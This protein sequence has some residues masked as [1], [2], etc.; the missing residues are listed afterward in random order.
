MSLDTILKGVVRSRLARFGLGIATFLTSV[1]QTRADIPIEE[2]LDAFLGNKPAIVEVYDPSVAGYPT[3]IPSPEV[4]EI[5]RNDYIALGVNPHPDEYWTMPKISYGIPQT[6]ADYFGTV[7]DIGNFFGEIAIENISVEGRIGG[8]NYA[9]PSSLIQYE[10]D[11]WYHLIVRAD[12]P[13]TTDIIEGGIPGQS[14]QIYFVND[15]TSSLVGVGEWQFGSQRYNILVDSDQDGLTNKEETDIHFTD[16][17]NPDTD[18]DNRRDS[19][20]IAQGTDPLVCD[21]PVVPANVVATD[22]LADIIQVTWASS[23]GATDYR[24][25]RGLTDNSAQASVISDWIA[26]T[27]VT[28]TTASQNPANTYYYFVVARND[29]V[30]GDFS[31]SDQGSVLCQI[32]AAPANVD[33]TDDLA[34]R[35]E[36]TW[37]ASPEVEGA[38]NYQVYRG[39]SINP[40][41]AIAISGSLASGITSFTDTTAQVLTGYNYFVLA[42]DV[43]GTSSFSSPDQG[44]VLYQVP[45]APYSGLITNVGSFFGGIDA[46]T[47]SIEARID[48]V[49]YAQDSSITRDG[50]WNLHYQTTIKADDPYTSAIEGGVTGQMADI[51][52]VGG[53]GSIDRLLGVVEWQSGS[54]AYDISVDLDQDSLSDAE[55]TYIHST[56]YSN[57]DTDLDGLNDGLEVLTYNTNPLLMDTDND[58]LNDYKELVSYDSNPFEPDTDGDGLTDGLEVNTYSTH[59]SYTDTDND[60]LDDYYEIFTSH[61]NPISWDTDDDLLWDNIELIWGINPLLADSD[62][63]GLTDYFEARY[64][65]NRYAT[66]TYYNPFHPTNNPR[67]TDLNALLADTDADGFSDSNELDTGYNPL[68]CDAPRD[69]SNID[70][71]TGHIGQVRITWEAIDHAKE[72]RVYRGAPSSSFQDAKPISGWQAETSYTDTTA[73]PPEYVGGGCFKKGTETPVEYIYWVRARNTCGNSD[74]SSPDNGYALKSGQS[75]TNS[76]A[77]GDPVMLLLA[78]AGLLLGSRRKPISETTNN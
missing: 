12:D 54:N 77:V 60:E 31:S 6:P 76:A 59:P 34:D 68:E 4:L 71:T 22:N 53:S 18:S 78:G 42:E 69:M 39:L 63:D 50:S 16:P 75:T 19:Y 38:N 28:D 29:C 13:E 72:Y 52:F 56:D 64:D 33:A 27:S 10:S 61:T 9:Q 24:V 66:R 32:P 14:V 65:E 58:G 70:A 1:G 36:V 74:P 3:K 47:L 5:F 15:G 41:D 21:K 37:N 23:V 73:E 55:E 2:V 43:C 62:G 49:N 25:Y 67:G 7:N 48:G 17:N 46:S 11:T 51:Y 57:A 30:V 44:S 20:E 8:I 45:D 40:A 35:V 26:E